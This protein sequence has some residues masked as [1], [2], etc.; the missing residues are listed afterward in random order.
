MQG[1]NFARIVLLL[2]T[3]FTLAQTASAIEEVSPL[4]Q[5]R[6]GQRGVYARY[7]PNHLRVGCWSTAFGQILYHH[8]LFPG[9]GL[10]R[11]RCS[12]EN[13]AIREDIGAYEFNEREL[14]WSTDEA[15]RYLYTI[16]VIIQK[17]F[18][19]GSY[20]LKHKKRAGMIQRYFNCTTKF[21]KKLNGKALRD[22]L[23]SELKQG[24]PVLIHLRDRKK[25]RYH[26]A[27]VDGYKTTRDAPLFHVNMGHKGRDDDWFRFDHAVG[28]YDDVTY[29]RIITII[30]E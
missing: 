19:T 20:V 7:A 8:R 16:A 6:W 22:L 26:A 1:K 4:L 30:P 2:A 9:E 28:K 10:V 12:K 25:R 5:T 21:Y 23:K 11:Y 29:H 27:V 3:V 15:A 13:I 14:S 17:D 18:G 24:R